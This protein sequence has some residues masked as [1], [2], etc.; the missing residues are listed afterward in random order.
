[1][2]HRRHPHFQDVLHDYRNTAVRGIEGGV[3][4]TQA[5]VGKAAELRDLI[6]RP[7]MRSAP[8]L[9]NT[10]RFCASTTHT[11]VGQDFEDAPIHFEIREG[12]HVRTAAER[13]RAMGFIGCNREELQKMSPDFPGCLR[14]K[15]RLCL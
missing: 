5:L 2:S 13:P 9:H 12:A 7:V 14:A 6:C 8:S 15:S 11:P 1:V 10:M 4:L 3:G